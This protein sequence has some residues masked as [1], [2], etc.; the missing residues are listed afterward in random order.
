MTYAKATI[1]KRS[2]QMNNSFNQSVTFIVSTN[3]EDSI[4]LISSR[5]ST[6]ISFIWFRVRLTVS[7]FAYFY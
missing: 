7:I 4:W 1:I 2:Q 5:G 6:S 3:S